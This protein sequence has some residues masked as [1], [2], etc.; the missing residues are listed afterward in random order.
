VNFLDDF[1]SDKEISFQHIL[2]SSKEKLPSNSSNI[3]FYKRD[4]NSFWANSINFGL[5]KLD[6]KFKRDHILIFN[7][8]S[9]PSFKGIQ[10]AFNLIKNYDLVSGTIINKSTNEII[11]GLNKEVGY[12]DFKLLTQED[13]VERAVCAHG[14]F[15]L[16]S[17]EVFKEIKHI[18]NFSHTFLDFFISSWFIKN[19]K[20][21]SR[22]LYP[23]GFTEEDLEFRYRKLKSDKGIFRPGRSNIKDIFNFYKFYKNFFLALTLVVYHIFKEV[24]SIFRNS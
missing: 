16:F 19:R 15:L 23:V 7:H 22:T 21:I 5:K 14:N 1:A 11:F 4:K 17:F 3:K 10:E 12:L 20:K 8:D 2:I 18:P 6:S 9:F 24:L 13:T